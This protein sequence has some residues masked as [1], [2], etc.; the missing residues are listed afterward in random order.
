MLNGVTG[1]DTAPAQKLV[2]LDPNHDQEPALVVTMVAAHH[3]QDQKDNHE[4]VTLMSVVHVSLD[5]I[6]Q[7]VKQ[8]LK[9]LI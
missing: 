9:F 4:T 2:Q 5:S 7:I 6:L 1:V 3:A 8:L